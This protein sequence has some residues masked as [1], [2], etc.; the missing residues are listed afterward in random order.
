LQEKKKK[1]EK[2]KKERKE[3]ILLVYGAIQGAISRQ[4]LARKVLGLKWSL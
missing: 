3:K 1:K 4:I 2:K